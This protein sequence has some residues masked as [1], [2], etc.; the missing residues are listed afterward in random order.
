MIDDD[1]KVLPSMH[2]TPKKNKIPSKARFIVAAK[3]CS[4]KKLALFVTK[5]LKMF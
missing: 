4:L 2:W 1:M 5:V 3:K